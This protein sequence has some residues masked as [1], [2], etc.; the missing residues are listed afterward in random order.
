MITIS[1]PY[2]TTQFLVMDILVMDVTH[3]RHQF[4]VSKLL[5]LG[6]VHQFKGMCELGIKVSS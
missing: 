4:L 3:W 2:I 6:R 5:L 1:I